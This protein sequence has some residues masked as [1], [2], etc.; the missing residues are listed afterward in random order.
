MDAFAVLCEAITDTFRRP[1]D[2]GPDATG[3]ILRVEGKGPLTTAAAHLFVNADTSSFAAMATD[4]PLRRESSHMR[5]DL[6][7][8]AQRQ[9]LS[10]LRTRVASC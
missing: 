1:S 7:H 2:H 4:C 3:V 5:R 8:C 6:R 10:P 9:P